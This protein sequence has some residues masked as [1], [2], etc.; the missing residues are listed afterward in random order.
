MSLNYSVQLNDPT[1]VGGT[2]DNAVLVY[3]LQQARADARLGLGR[4][5][6]PIGHAAGGLRV[7]LRFL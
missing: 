6:Q 3:D 7:D 2:A 5:Q 1:N 4:L